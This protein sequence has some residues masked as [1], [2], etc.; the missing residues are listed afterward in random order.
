MSCAVFRKKS[1]LQRRSPR[2]EIQKIDENRLLL[3]ILTDA[4]LRIRAAFYSSPELQLNLF[5]IGF[6]YLFFSN[7][8]KTG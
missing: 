8:V 1:T 3:K 6:Y 2:I 4:A 7:A 5:S